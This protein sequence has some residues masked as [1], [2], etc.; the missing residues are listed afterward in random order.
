MPE[1]LLVEIKVQI[2]LDVTMG[3][4]TIVYLAVVWS[5]F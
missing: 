4:E 5:L 1:V 2:L 3:I